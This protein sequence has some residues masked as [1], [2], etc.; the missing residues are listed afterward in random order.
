ML[1]RNFPNI[2]CVAAVL[3]FL[4]WS[5]G[6]N[7]LTN[8][9]V[10]SLTTA[11]W[12]VCIKSI[13]PNSNPELFYLLFWLVPSAFSLLDGNIQLVSWPLLSLSTATVFNIVVA[14]TIIATC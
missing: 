7:D 11:V 12:I 4:L 2:I 14:L 10:V 1:T 8:I 9:A 13:K 5:F 3:S 6:S